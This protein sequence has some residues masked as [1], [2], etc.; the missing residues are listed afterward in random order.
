MGSTIRSLSKQI[1]EA[2][3]VSPITS[4]SRTFEVIVGLLH[5]AMF[6]Q[7]VYFKYSISSLVNL[8]QPCHVIL[9]FQ[10]IALLSTT[11][12]G[13]LISIFILPALTGT[14]L[15]MLFPETTGLDQYLEM[16]AYWLQHYLI[17]AMPLYLLLRRN[18]LALQFCSLKTVCMGI[19]LLY[20]L[21]FSIY[22][23]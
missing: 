7:L 2:L 9:L 13:V 1:R 18:G 16:E 12:T 14:M 10:G 23:V 4:L 5:L 20:F 11:E 15:A 22:E 21:H 8:M 17:Q 6:A 19:W 3:K